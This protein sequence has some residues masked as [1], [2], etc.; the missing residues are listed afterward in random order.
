MYR[1]FS[2]H[3]DGVAIRQWLVRFM[4]NVS[5]LNE[6]SRVEV[7]PHYRLGPNIAYGTILVATQT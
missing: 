7:V 4:D 6:V 1:A 2:E 5:G 3:S